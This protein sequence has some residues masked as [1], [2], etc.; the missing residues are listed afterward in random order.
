[1]TTKE[2]KRVEATL[3]VRVNIADYARRLVNAGGDQD[4]ADLRELRGR[5]NR[6]QKTVD[7]TEKR[8]DQESPGWRER[9]ARSEP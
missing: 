9:A 2:Q 6:A 7:A 3:R 1:M 4:R 8:L 5:M